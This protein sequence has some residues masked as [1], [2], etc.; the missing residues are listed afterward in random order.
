M[1]KLQLAA[2][3]EEE[4]FDEDDEEDEDFELEDDEDLEG[5]GEDDDRVE[6]DDF[7]TKVSQPDESSEMMDEDARS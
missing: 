6:G 2:E 3:D 7:A 4:E 1:S 5:D